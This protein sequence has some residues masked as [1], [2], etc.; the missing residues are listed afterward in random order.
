MSF[1]LNC[2]NCGERSVNEF[3]FGGEVVSRPSP[4]ASSEEWGSYFFISDPNVA[5]SQ[6]GVVEP[7][8]RLPPLVPGSPG[9][10][11]QCC[12]GNFLAG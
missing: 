8:L 5:G 6:T 12:A 11:R 4:D 7:P 10:D 2:P 1:L 9:H 3:R